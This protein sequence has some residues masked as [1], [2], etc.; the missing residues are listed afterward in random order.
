MRTSCPRCHRVHSGACGIPP[1]STLLSVSL[2]FGARMGRASPQGDTAQ[3]LQSKPSPEMHSTAFLEK[4][5]AETQEQLVKVMEMLKVL[6]VEAEGY[7]DL[8]DKESRLATL[9]KQLVGQIAARQG[10]K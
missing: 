5:L 6:P 8:L 9:I 1:K 4:G 2:G 3:P 7:A 10:M